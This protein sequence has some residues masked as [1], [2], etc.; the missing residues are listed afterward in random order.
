MDVFYE[1]KKVSSIPTL[2]NIFI[3]EEWWRFSARLGFRTPILL[4]PNLE[5]IKSTPVRVGHARD[6]LRGFPDASFLSLG[7]AVGHEVG[8]MECPRGFGVP[9]GRYP[10][11]LEERGS[12][13]DP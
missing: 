6:Q 13:G 2:L 3:M 10:P 1:V 4:H 12:S 8:E 9:A 7:F 5:G 11:G